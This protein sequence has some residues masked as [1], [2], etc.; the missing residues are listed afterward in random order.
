MKNK[1][2][3]RWSGFTV[4]LLAICLMAFNGATAAEKTEIL[5]GAPVSM[6][7]PTAMQ[8]LEQKW[9]YEQAVADF[10]KERGGI[11]VREIGKRVPIKLI[12]HDDESDAGKAVAAMERLI[13][14]EKVDFF[15]ST[16]Y[17]MRIHPCAVIAEK[18]KKYHHA[19]VCWPETYFKGEVFK[20]TTDLFGNPTEMSSVPFQIFEKQLPEAQRP[21]RMGLFLMEDPAGDIFRMRFNEHGPRYGYPSFP[22]DEPFPFFS[23]DYSSL[24][25]KAKAKKIDALILL[26][27]PQDSITLT[28]QMK[29]NDFSVPYFHG[30]AGTWASQFY[31]ALGKDADYIL[32]DGFWSKEYPYPGAKELGERF[33]KAHKRDSV[34][35]GLFYAQAKILFEAIDMAGTL[36]GAKVREVVLKTDWKDTVLGDVKYN[37]K[38]YAFIPSVALQWWKGKQR[39]VYPF[40]PGGWKVKLAPPWDKR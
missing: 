21:K 26:G 20:W 30:W 12:L 36:D 5:I 31:E 9:A 35:I 14:V 7:G 32:A 10:N 3:L 11:L 6:S 1:R 4:L 2:I 25:L 24:V 37:E 16:Q 27:I 38:G 22:V 34:S 15:L 23:R 33:Y 13:R 18:Y 39:L 19:S 8:G 28:R 29:E 40:F 17:D